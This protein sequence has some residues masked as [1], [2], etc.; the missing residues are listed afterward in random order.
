MRK[1]FIALGVL[2]ALSA[3]ASENLQTPFELPQQ[4]IRVVPTLKNDGII[5]LWATRDNNQGTTSTESFSIYD[6]DFNV[7]SEFSV[8][9]PTISFTTYRQNKKIVGLSLTTISYT[10]TRYD[11]GSPHIEE[12]LDFF[13]SNYSPNVA[14]AT[15]Q[16]GEQVIADTYFR[17]D[18]FGNQYPHAFFIH[19][20]D[21]ESTGEWE[22][23]YADYEYIMGDDPNAAIREENT[24][25]SVGMAYVRLMNGKGNLGEYKITRGF[26]GSECNYALPITE[27]VTFVKD[28]S[29][30]KEWGTR[31]QIKGFE[32]FDCNSTLLTTISF[33]SGWYADIY[34]PLVSYADFSGKQYVMVTVYNKDVSEYSTIV[35]QVVN[36]T[37]IKQ[38][39]MTP[40]GKISP[41]T[42]RQGETIVIEVDEKFR[43]DVCTVKVI[44]TAGM[45]ILQTLIAP[46][47]TEVTLSTSDL[48]KGAYIVYITGKSEKIEC[49]KIIVR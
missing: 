41:R 35:Y 27:N 2:I 15:L 40:G 10:G 30:Y 33:P 32:I 11:V 13:K 4:E 14:I 17:Q 47:E 22:K 49:A 9:L 8:D 46:G 18:L 37:E 39:T 5:R 23:A 34:D 1:N 48:P 43:N 42:P 21:S 3:T 29:S 36:S 44:S 45:N 12:A 7:I 25:R 24:T 31:P 26:F 38:L 16:N 20:D 6:E 28:Y 19:K